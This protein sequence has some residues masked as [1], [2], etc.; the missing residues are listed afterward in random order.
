[1]PNSMA[2]Q[3][4]LAKKRSSRDVEEAKIRLAT[5][6]AFKDN[7]HGTIRDVFEACVVK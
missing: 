6:N 3:G 5:V 4:K 1:M 2:I 7:M